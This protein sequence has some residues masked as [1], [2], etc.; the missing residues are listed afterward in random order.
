MQK[1]KNIERKLA[2]NLENDIEE[3]PAEAEDID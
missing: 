2:I 3:A 1:Q